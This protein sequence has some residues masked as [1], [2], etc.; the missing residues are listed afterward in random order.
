MLYNPATNTG[1]VADT[2]NWQDTHGGNVAL[3]TIGYNGTLSL[4]ARTG[5]TLS[6]KGLLF[7]VNALARTGNIDLLRRVLGEVD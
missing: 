7:A 4:E 3:D 2:D 1:A 5:L 6:Q